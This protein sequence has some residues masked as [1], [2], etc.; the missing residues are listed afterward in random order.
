MRPRPSWPMRSRAWVASP[1]GGRVWRRRPSRRRSSSWRLHL[2]RL[3]HRHRRLRRRRRRRHRRRH[4]LCVLRQEC[5]VHTMR[6]SWTECKRAP[7]R[8]APAPPGATTHQCLLLLPRHGHAG[9]GMRYPPV[10]SRSMRSLQDGRRRAVNGRARH[11]PLQNRSRSLEEPHGPTRRLAQEPALSSRRERS[12]F[13]CRQC[14]KQRGREAACRRHRC[15]VL[16]AA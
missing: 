14:R 4:R 10:R 13:Q 2:L 8:L 7:V 3:L 1:A 9:T 5:P 12:R 15:R 6:S 11:L 16:A